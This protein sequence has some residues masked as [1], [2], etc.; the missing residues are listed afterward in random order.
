MGANP[1]TGGVAFRVWAPNASSVAVAG[2]FNSWSTTANPLASDGGGSGTWSVDLA[3]AAVDDEYQYVI[4]GSLWRIDPW[5]R[6]VTNSV[7]NGIITD[8]TYSFGSFTTPNWNEMVIYEMH[9]GTFNDTAGGNPGTWDSAVSKL[10]HLQSM[11]VNVVEVMPICEFAGDFSWGYNPAHPFAPESIYGTPTDMRDFVEECHDR[12]IAVLIDVVYNHWGPSDLD[13]WQSDGWSTNNMGGIY[14]FQDWRASTP[15]GDTRPDYGR[16]EVRTYI[17][18]NAI[19]WLTDYNADGL[20]WDSTV[21]IRTQNNGGGGDIS[22]GWSLMQYVNNEINSV[23]SG[24]I[25]IAEDLQNNE[26][27]TK[28]TGAG[29]AGFDS[30]W[31][32]GFVHPIRDAVI[33][34][35]DSSRNMYSVRDAITHN[36]NSDHVQRVVY[37]ESHDEVANGKSRVPEEIWPG[38]ASSW[39]SKKRSTLGA[40]ITFTSPGIPMIFQGQE[41]LEDGYFS[42]TDPVDWAKATTY[43]GLVD[44]YGDLIYLRRNLGGKTAG[45]AGPYVNVHHVNNTN[46]VIAYHRWASGGAGDDVIIVAN[47]SSTGYSSYNVG[48]PS[49]GTW[50]VRFNSDWS[51][52][53]S[54][55]GNWASNNVTANSGA[56]DGMSYNGNVGVGPYTV[57]ILSKD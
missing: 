32:A 56:K 19:S 18:D 6:E 25:S 33:A 22:D 42:D 35:S 39:A 20:R 13:L 2:D 1:F 48:F 31:D 5:A 23:A 21:N 44:L 8:N 43:S 53:D 12:G 26:W 49:G 40:A 29:G 50:K 36:Y 7:G 28:T 14:F 52:Y 55:F 16:G 30:Q 10:N 51:G 17:R 11:G 41:F 45:L 34:S 37:T 57:V 38:N 27:L 47:F 4:N 15:W 9:V 54:G 24:K 3:S 46:K